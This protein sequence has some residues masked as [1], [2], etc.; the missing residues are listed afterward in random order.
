MRLCHLYGFLK[1]ETSTKEERIA[2]PK[3]SDMFWKNILDK[4]EAYSEPCQASKMKCFTKI[5]Y[6]MAKHIQTIRCQQPT[7]CL[8]MF[9]HFVDYFRKNLHLRSLTRF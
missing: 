9:D 3:I 2:V 8:S 6:K 4:A 5:I 1:A 7:N